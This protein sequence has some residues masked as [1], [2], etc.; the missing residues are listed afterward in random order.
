[1][2][3]HNVWCVCVCVWRYVW[4]GVLWRL[5][6]V[7]WQHNVWC[8]C[9]RVWHSVWRGALWRLF[10]VMWQCNIWC[11]CV[12]FCVESYAVEVICGNAAA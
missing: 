9:V 12:A 1:M 11:V 7:M 3:Q 2:W 5:F 10:V 8:V 6:L 4:R